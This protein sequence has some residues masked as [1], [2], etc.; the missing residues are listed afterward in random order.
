MED[1]YLPMGWGVNFV[2]YDN[3]GW[4]DLFVV[5]GHLFPEVDTH[6][7][8]MT[9]AEEPFLYHNNAKGRFIN[10]SQCVQYGRYV[11]R[12]SAVADL[13]ND[14]RLD[15]VIS[16]LDSKPKVLL[17]S[18]KNG[19]HWITLTLIGTRSNRDAIGARISAFYG[20]QRQVAAVRAG[21]SYLSYSDPRIHFGLG[22]STTIDRLEIRWPSGRVQTLT[23]VGADRFLTVRE[24]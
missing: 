2:D 10:V 1:S 18:L 15:L 23:H 24:E 3:D 17:N 16:N 14:G 12:G 22:S 13:N 8:D 7:T 21:S 5:M 6:A 4:E 20:N 9:Y 11:G 19:N